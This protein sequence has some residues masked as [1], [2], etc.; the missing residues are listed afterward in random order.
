MNRNLLEIV[1][2]TLVLVVAGLFVTFAYSVAQLHEVAGYQVFARFN[3]ADGIKTG[4]DVRI[5]GIKV[6]T[7][8]STTLDPNT[9]QA[10]V[11]MSLD[12]AIKLPDDTVAQVASSG[13]LGDKF[14]QL[15]PGA[16]DSTIQ[17]GGQIKMTQS[18]VSLESLFGQVAYSLSHP[19][20]QGGNGAP[21]SKPGP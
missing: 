8:L 11:V 4:G 1:M 15:E 6:G 12:K 9:F 18:A 13:L 5:S 17:P 20:G 14:L 3:H 7:V 21:A 10:V 16:S 2:G 19:A